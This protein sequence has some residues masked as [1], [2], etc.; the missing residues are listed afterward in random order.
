[1]RSLIR[2]LQSLTSLFSTPSSSKLRA[3]VSDL[4]AAICVLA[5]PEGHKMVMAAMSDYRVVFDEAFRFEELIASLRLP[6]A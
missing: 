6:E 3:L 4:L 1:M 5:I 2:L